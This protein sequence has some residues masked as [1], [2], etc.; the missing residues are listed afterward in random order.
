[1]VSYD[2]TGVAQVL[3][4]PIDCD[5][6]RGCESFCKTET[7][8]ICLNV[9]DVNVCQCLSPTDLCDVTL[10]ERRIQGTEADHT[11]SS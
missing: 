8:R 7:A 11:A 9:F 1:M 5:H 3:R 10:T 4:I 6:C 2:R